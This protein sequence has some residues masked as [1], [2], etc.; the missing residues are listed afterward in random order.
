MSMLTWIAKLLG[1]SPPGPATFRGAIK[2]AFMRTATGAKQLIDSGAASDISRLADAD[3]RFNEAVVL[4]KRSEAE[5]KF[6]AARSAQAKTNR[7]VM[8]AEEFADKVLAK[9][10]DR[11]RRQLRDRMKE[12]GEAA[13]STPDRADQIR[14]ELQELEEQAFAA[15]LQ[16]VKDLITE[17]RAAGGEVYFDRRNLDSLEAGLSGS[18][19]PPQI[20]AVPPRKLDPLDTEVVAAVARAEKAIDEVSTKLAELARRIDE[21]PP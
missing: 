8:E 12:L 9:R 13:K 4:Q 21:P 3:V 1:K 14:R 6:Q 15:K 19:P 2:A 10:R 5:L 16:E 7:V 20:E 17:L 11:I 18:V